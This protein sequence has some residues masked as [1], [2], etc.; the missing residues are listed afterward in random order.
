MWLII[1]WM[2]FIFTMTL[3]V[4]GEGLGTYHYILYGFV[5]L[6]ITYIYWQL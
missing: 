1:I 2:L 4:M 6:Y 5:M 3:G